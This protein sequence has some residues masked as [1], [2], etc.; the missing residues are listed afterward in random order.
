[1][2]SIIKKGDKAIPSQMSE[3]RGDKAIPSQIW[4][5]RAI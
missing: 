1:V 5:L 2:I 4:E 3:L